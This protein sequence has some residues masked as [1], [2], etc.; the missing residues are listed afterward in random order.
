MSVPCQCVYNHLHLVQWS[1]RL[2][3]CGLGM[4]CFNILNLVVECS[5]KRKQQSTVQPNTHS[6]GL[7]SPNTL[8]AVAP[9]S[10]KWPHM[11]FLL[12][13]AA[14]RFSAATA[15]RTSKPNTT[16]ELKAITGSAV[17][18]GWWVDMPLC[19][20]QWFIIGPGEVSTL[21]PSVIHSASI[22]DLFQGLFCDDVL[23][24]SLVFR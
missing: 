22:W 3:G 19:S 13:L 7:I 14:L 5:H 15:P 21:W 9:P 8:S 4:P 11:S 12:W 20:P 17:W 2:C 1:I 23:G 6:S 10:P 18:E 24:F 16:A